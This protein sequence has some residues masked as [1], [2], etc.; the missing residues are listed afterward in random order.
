MN[1]VF[2]IIFPL[3]VEMVMSEKNVL[4]FTA[5]NMFYFYLYSILLY[6]ISFYMFYFII[7]VYLWK[8]YF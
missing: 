7:S 8:T 1:K 2:I 6:Y 4:Q 3:I 5:Q